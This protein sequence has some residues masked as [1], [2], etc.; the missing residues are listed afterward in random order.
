MTDAERTSA[1]PSPRSRLIEL[2]IG[3][4]LLVGLSACLQLFEQILGPSNLGGAIFGALAVDI[5]AGRTGVRWDWDTLPLDAPRRAI[6]RVGAGAGVAVVAGGL[7][8]AIAAAMRWFR[9]TGPVAPSA[10]I[11]FAVARAAAI[12]VRDEILFR[13]IPLAAMSRARVPP[14]VAR[15]FAAL[16]SGAAI[17]AVPGATPAALAL[18]VASGWLF[19]ALWE[20]DRGA[21]AAVGAHAAWVLLLGSFIHGGVMDLEWTTGELAVGAAADGMPAWLAAGILL[22]MGFGVA[23]LPWPSAAQS[24]AP[25]E[26]AG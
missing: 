4:G 24:A 18:A 20:R 17:V 13:G 7:A 12:S 23:R 6:A 19:A 26:P 21:W 11:A 22:V 5:A 15:A 10:T 9:A 3:A 1:P 25:R 2:G 8:L 14:M 16:V